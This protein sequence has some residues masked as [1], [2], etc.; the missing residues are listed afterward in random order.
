[1]AIIGISYVEFEKDGVT[2]YEPPIFKYTPEVYKCNL[3]EIFPGPLYW[4]HSTRLWCPYYVPAFNL[5]PDFYPKSCWG[6]DK[7]ERARYTRLFNDTL[8]VVTC[9]AP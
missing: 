2:P 9:Y 3:S 1:V 6:M 8:N 5:L 4:T 7:T